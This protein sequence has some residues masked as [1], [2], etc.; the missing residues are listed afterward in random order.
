MPCSVW[1]KIDLHV[2]SHV[3]N[4]TKQGDYDGC[5]LTYEKL[6]KALKREQI[7]LFSITDHNTINIELYT[8]LIR[9]RKELI[10]NNL[11]FIIGAE[12]DFMDEAIHDDI[13]HM[14]IMF[15]TFDLKKIEK[16]LT[17]VYKKECINDIDDKVRQ[18]SLGTFFD[19]VFNNGIQN[20][21]TIPHFNNKNKGIP[22][23][24]QI[25]KF[26]YTVFNALEDS[27]NRNNL[28]RSLKAYK[29]LNYRDVPIV[30][31]SDNHDIDIYPCGKD[32][33]RSKQTSMYILGNI[34]FPFN[35]IKT[36][37]Q[38]VNTRVS[39]DNISMR[40]VVDD[41]RRYIKAIN[42]EGY[43]L[44]LSKYQ[45]TIIGGFGSGKSFLLDLI[46][47][48]KRNVNARYA[49]LAKK[50]ENFNIIFSDGT[51]RESLSEVK[52]DVK[53]IKFDQYKEIYFKTELLETDKSLLKNNLHIEFPELDIIEEFDE[54][55]IKNCVNN[56]IANYTNSLNIT[57][58]L[59]YDAISRRYEKA[60]SFK[61]EELEKLYEEPRY[62]EQLKENLKT[63]SERKILSR[64][65]YSEEEKQNITFTRDIIIEK[66]SDYKR[67]SRK[68]EEILNILDRKI[69]SI[70]ETVRQNN[71][72]ISS[73]IKILEEIKDDIKTYIILLKDLKN[74][75]IGFERRYS[76][77]IYEQ[78]KNKMSKKE[79]YAYELIARYRANEEYLDY[80]LD[81]I[82]P[83]YREEDLF[84]S[85]IKTLENNGTFTQ[86]QTFDQR[87]DHFTSK[88]YGNFKTICYDIHENGIS[89][90][91]KS[92]GE[93][94]NVIINI[95]FY[96]IEDYSSKGISSIVI[97]DQPEDNLD[98][99]GIKKEVVE[100]IRDMK[101]KNSLP[102][103]ICVTHNANISITA[104]SENIILAKQENGK[105]YYSGSGIENS[106]FIEDVCSVVEG[107]R[108]ALK[109]RGVKFNVPII[110]ELERIL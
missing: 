54:T 26:V 94:A 4:R 10:N 13:F 49:D 82:R 6:V 21:I 110:K 61:T 53:I 58:I 31:F 47:N 65:V 66:N 81:I 40:H 62:F 43:T 44:P 59:S 1:L 98:N 67:L 72:N 95:I 55:E 33:N 23:K 42:I 91:K 88:Y 57:D 15:D 30:V 50:Y 104:D 108:D 9:R 32:G 3:S 45:N 93:K 79:F 100:R 102:Q 87:V 22:S 41:C 89:I 18:I 35:S 27:N 73:N 36:A 14:L 48:G 69:I 92:A 5:D 86:N 99:K 77:K 2:H 103:V 17:D 51:T 24:D 84:K 37:F 52:D 39:I 97:L 63:E 16:V 105:C 28:V 64:N 107:G 85:I 71:A 38:D 74:K 12:I 56:L 76:K 96:I 60:Y 70:N 101:I 46:L 109:K 20:V 80:I 78:L 106:D 90:M 19:S 29:N 68:I 7:N 83:Q 25:D 11:N 34:M 75:S 8:E